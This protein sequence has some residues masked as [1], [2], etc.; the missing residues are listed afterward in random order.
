M[1]FTYPRRNVYS[2]FI[3]PISCSQ[4]EVRKYKHTTSRVISSVH[5]TIFPDCEYNFDVGHNCANIEDWDASQGLVSESIKQWLDATHDLK[6]NSLHLKARQGSQWATADRS[7]NS[8]DR[9]IGP[10]SGSF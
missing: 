6:D 3:E 9:S 1:D 10:F 4:A 7:T 5:L 2:C 8:L